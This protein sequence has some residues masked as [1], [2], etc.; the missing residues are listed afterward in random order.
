MENKECSLF[1]W[2]LVGLEIIDRN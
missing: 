1:L 2:A